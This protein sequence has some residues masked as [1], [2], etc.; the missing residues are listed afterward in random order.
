MFREICVSFVYTDF[1][2]SV[3]LDALE[4]VRG[5]FNLQSTEDLS[6]DHFKTLKSNGGIRGGDFV[7]AGKK[8]TAESKTGGL[9]TPGSGNKKSAAATFG[10][11]MIVAAFAGVAALVAL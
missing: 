11:S 9:G 1:Y 2:L 5:D 4:D 3:T 7:C 10:V 8:E 6:C